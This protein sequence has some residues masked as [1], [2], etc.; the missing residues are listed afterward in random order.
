MKYY[1]IKYSGLLIFPPL[2][3]SINSRLI[4]HDNLT[5]VDNHQY[6]ALFLWGNM[7]I[8]LHNKQNNAWKFGNMKLFLVLNRISWSTLEINFIFP[9]I[10]VLVLYFLIKDSFEYHISLNISRTK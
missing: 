3:K 6:T 2:I 8:F 5:C 1:Y 7:T 9:H 4:I 10:H